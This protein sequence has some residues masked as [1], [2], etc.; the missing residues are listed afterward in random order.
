MLTLTFYTIKLLNIKGANLN[1]FL[2]LNKILLFLT[3]CQNIL[4]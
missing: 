4:F 1:Q 2:E 3:V